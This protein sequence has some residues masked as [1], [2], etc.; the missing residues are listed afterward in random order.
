MRFRNPTQLMDKATHLLS[1]LVIFQKT[2][3]SSSL[4]ETATVGLFL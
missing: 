3:V 4:L 2:D 1:V